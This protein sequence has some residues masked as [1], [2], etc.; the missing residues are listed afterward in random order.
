[1]RIA[2][3]TLLTAVSAPSFAAGTDTKVPSVD[4]NPQQAA[5][6]VKAED[7]A[8]KKICKRIEASESRLGAQRVCLTREQWKQRDAENAY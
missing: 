5:Q 6:P 3:I 1:M 2:L 7:Q 4:A 8:E